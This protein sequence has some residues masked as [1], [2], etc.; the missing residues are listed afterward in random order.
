MRSV[1]N[2]YCPGGSERW[3]RIPAGHDAGKTMFY[4]DHV[5]GNDPPVSTVLFVHGNPECSYTYRHIC[6]ELIARGAPLRLVAPDHIGFGV[7]DQATFEMVDMHH[8]ANLKQLI[9][10]LGLRQVTLVIHDWGGPIGIGAFTD[11]MNLVTS[12]IV[13]NSTVFPL[14]GDGI[15]YANWPWKRLPWSE[16]PS[17]V[18]D[19]VWGGA[20]AGVVLDAFPTPVPLL[21]AKSMLYQIR[22]ALRMNP[23]HSPLWVFSESLRSKANARSSKR[24]V[25]QTP[26]WGHGYTYSDPTLG[27]QDNRPYYRDIQAAVPAWGPE[28][29]NIPVAGHFGDWDPCGKESVIQQWQQV[30]PSMKGR[31]H[32]YPGFG[33]F[34]EEYKGPEIA[35]SILALNGLL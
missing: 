35:D 23:R 9:D 13:I 27:E 25:L 6:G 4:Y 15:T 10:H 8:T 28:G 14:P 29:A 12:L 16:L 31:T 34:I 11:A 19:S 1:P 17:V 2:D 26:V 24:N 20:A 5:I 21:L 22:F 3:F 33:H 32:V 18:P 30:L 7:S